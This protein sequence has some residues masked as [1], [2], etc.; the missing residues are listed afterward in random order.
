[1]N[2]TTSIQTYFTAEAPQDVAALAAAFA[3]DAVLQDEGARH[4]GPEAIRD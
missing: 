1:M 3:D 4:R 2:L